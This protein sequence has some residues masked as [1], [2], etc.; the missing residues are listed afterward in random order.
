MQTLS[1][2]ERAHAVDAPFADFDDWADSLTPGLCTACCAD[3]W[4][5]ACGWW[6]ADGTRLCPKRHERQPR[7]S[8]DHD[9]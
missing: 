6:H 8:P 1:V 3:A 2:L 4:A 7:F 5:G 9:S